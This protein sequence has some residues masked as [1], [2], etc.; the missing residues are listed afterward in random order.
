MLNKCTAESGDGFHMANKYAH[1]DVQTKGLSCPELIL[2]HM[3]T[4]EQ[5]AEWLHR[6]DPECALTRTGLRRL[7]VAGVI[8]SVRNGTKYML[9][10]ENLAAFLY[11]TY[12]GM[13]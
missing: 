4:I 3:R 11:G 10:L 1:S 12:T 13:R 2:P 8:P 7:V 9:A 6:T 5:A